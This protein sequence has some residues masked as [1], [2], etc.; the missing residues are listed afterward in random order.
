MFLG[1]KTSQSKSLSSPYS[2]IPALIA[3]QI[4]RDQICI[5]PKGAG[6]DSPA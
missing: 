6:Q 1:E 5:N 4:G 2:D 3:G